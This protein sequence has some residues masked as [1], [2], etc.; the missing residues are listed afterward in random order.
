MKK[1]LFTI[2]LVLLAAFIVWAA[3]EISGQV[4]QLA[5]DAGSHSADV[6]ILSLETIRKPVG[7]QGPWD[8]EAKIRKDILAK[9]SQYDK[10]R[11]KARSEAGKAGAVSEATKAEVQAS[12]QAFK[13]SCDEYSAFWQS[14]GQPARADLASVVGQ[15][16]EKSGK[17]LVNPYDAKVQ[18]SLQECQ[19]HLRQ[20]RDRY[21]RH[22]IT[23]KDISPQDRADMEKTLLPRVESLYQRLKAFSNTV[24]NFILQIQKKLSGGGCNGGGGGGGGGDGAGDVAPKEPREV[25]D[26]RDVD[27]TARELETS[28]QHL[29]LEVRGLIK[30][31]ESILP[32]AFSPTACFGAALGK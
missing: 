10:L 21:V 15:I 17:V 6:E 9:Q 16:R 24:S 8:K 14:V 26:A 28:G 22:A 25:R 11:T 20:S 31:D 5:Q 30:M 23:S 4:N 18:K 19:K 29:D 2:G 1:I 13:G 32:K 12:I 3:A 7:V 27:R